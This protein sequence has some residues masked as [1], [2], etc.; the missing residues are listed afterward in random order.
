MIPSY[1][2]V[3]LPFLKFI[4][5]GREYSKRDVINEITS[6][7]NLTEEEKKQLLP[8]GQQPIIDNRVGWA[9]LYL[10]KA[11]L[12]EATKR[13]HMKITESGKDAIRQNPSSINTKF[14]S[15][16]PDFQQ[17]K[18]SKKVDPLPVD[19]IYDPDELIYRSYQQKLDEVKSELLD[20][21]KLTSPSF[22]ERLVLKL[23]RAMGY[24]VLG[25]TTKQSWDKGIDGIILEDNLGFNKIGFQAKRWDTNT[26]TGSLISTF[27]DDLKRN[28]LDKGVFVTSS[29]FDKGAVE[30]S[31]LSDPKVI[32]IDGEQLVDYMVKYNIGVQEYDIIRLKKIDRDFFSEEE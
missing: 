18:V 14:L 1:E 26:I 29:G 8:S 3:M 27:R 24:G 30:R 20:A 13:G 31:Q 32:L 17:F 16:Y 7:F 25:E 5:D 28:K 4:V 15:K 12:L 2:D 6:R 23:L 10:K 9:R 19:L 21:V 22:F 11:G